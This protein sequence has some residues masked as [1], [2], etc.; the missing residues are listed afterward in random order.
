MIPGLYQSAAGMLTQ[1]E[2]HQTIAENLASSSIPGH[3]RNQVMFQTILNEAGQND[4]I[5]ASPMMRLATD[6]SPGQL[7]AD[8]NPMHLAITG[9]GFFSVQLP[10]SRVAYT[11]NG[12]FHLNAQGEVVTPDGLKVLNASNGILFVSKPNEPVQIN[13]MGQ[14]LQKGNVVGSLQISKFDDP[15]KKLRWI[16]GTYFT[17]HEGANR[18][19]ATPKD[20]SLRQGF[21]ET[22]NVNP[23]QEM[24]SMIQATRMYEANQ[25]VLQAQDSALEKVIQQAS[26]R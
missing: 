26:A 13:E 6:F 11:R 10:D 24:V 4:K 19:D 22:S 14:V 9:N 21:L 18:T 15:S 5:T 20:Y 2:N 12:T 16:G 7:E 23:V 17:P 8:G 25:K 1:M 3:R